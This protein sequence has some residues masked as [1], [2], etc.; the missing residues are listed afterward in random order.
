MAKSAN[1]R[2]TGKAAASNAAKGVRAYDPVSGRFLQVDPVEGGCSNDYVYAFGDPVN[3]YDLTGLYTCDGK[4]H[5]AGGN[6]NRKASPW[7]TTYLGP[8][9]GG[10]LKSRY[11]T[12]N[13]RQYRCFIVRRGNQAI[14]SPV[15]YRDVFVTETQAYIGFEFGP[16]KGG[17][18]YTI[19]TDKRY[20][21]PN[22][23]LV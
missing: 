5:R 1:T 21:Y 8:G 22:R 13:Y 15:E 2:Q 6:R 3:Q 14:F 11:L 12:Y 17:K 7:R 20:S 18:T 10:V 16:A 4:W 9:Q 19:S 23:N